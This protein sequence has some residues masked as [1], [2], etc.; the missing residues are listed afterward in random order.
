MIS[1]LKIL[2]AAV[3]ISL[4]KY[5]TTPVV[6]AATAANPLICHVGLTEN[7]KTCEDAGELD[8]GFSEADR[9]IGFT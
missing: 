6:A 1:S 5:T 3:K 4:L 8:L 7:D 2:S 9:R